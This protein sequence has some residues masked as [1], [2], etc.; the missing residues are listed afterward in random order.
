MSPKENAALPLNL[1]LL[2]PGERICVAVSGGADSTALLLALH[3]RR[4]ELGIGLSA[5]HLHHGI[6]GA[7]ADRD[8]EF[9][10]QLCARIDVPL[11]VESAD[12]RANAAA[13]R[14]TLEEAARHAR[15]TTFERLLASGDATAVATAHTED[16]QAE[17]VM[18]KLMRGA[19]T[20]GLGG[21]SPVLELPAGRVVRPLLS[22][23]RQQVIAFLQARGEAWCEDSTNAEAMYTRNRVRHTLMPLLREFNPRIAAT[24]AQT[25][26]LAREEELRW[27]A[28]VA[29]LLGQMALPGRP[30]RGGGRAVATAA[31]EQT[32]AFELERLR[33]LD[34]PSRRRLLRGAAQRLGCR[35]SSAE[36]MRVLLLAGLAPRDTPPDP[37]VPTKP[38]SRLQMAGGLRVE[39]SVRELRLSRSS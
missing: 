10:R 5:V 7:E 30:V 15:L 39:R 4:L 23:S 17:T 2:R 29:R 35:L 1:S 22:A 16:D 25:A 32:L 8:A 31:G 34:L 14:E 21:I 24:L 38:N 27:Q 26:E 3:E 9:V 12:V 33:T 19:W 37:T 20:E 11:Q 13:D 18:M 36:T 6:R 28:E